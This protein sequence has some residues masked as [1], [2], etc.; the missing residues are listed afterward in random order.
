MEKH[1]IP[2]DIKV[3]G[4]RVETFPDGIGEA[5]DKLIKMLPSDNERPYYGISECTKEGIIYKAAALETYNGEAEDYDCEIF[6]IEKGDYFTQTVTN[7]RSKTASMKQ[8]FEDM[9]RDELSDR[10][11][12]CIE[13]Y[14]N[15]NEMVCMVKADQRKVLQIEFK[16]VSKELIQLLSSFS[17]K[18]INAIPFEGSWTAGQVA[19]HLVMSGL[20]FADLLNGPSKKTERTADE[21]V[22]TIKEIFLNFH[23]KLESPDF[24]KPA[25][26]NYDKSSLLSSLENIKVSITH[27]VK[28]SELAETCLAFELPVLGYLTRLEAINF[29]I[30]HT[31]RHI[32]Q[33]KKIYSTVTTKE[34]ET[35]S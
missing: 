32:H 4:S 26:I 16:A 25:I 30:A 5:F 24:I 10:S 7:W 13:V 27:A 34:F 23:N 18:Q 20:A 3:F 11:S 8:V 19:Q 31:Q 2:Q 21:F 6:T 22:A 35:A 17:L 12:P 33:L 29:V 1:N 15:E 14:N 28:T 9:F